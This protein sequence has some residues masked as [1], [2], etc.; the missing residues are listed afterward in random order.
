MKAFHQT[1]R[2]GK[3]RGQGAIKLA[4]TTSQSRSSITSINLAAA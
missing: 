3:M 4:S 2:L 1:Q